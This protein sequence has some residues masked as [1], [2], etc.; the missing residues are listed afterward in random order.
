MNKK[1]KPSLT[2]SQ[3]FLTSTKT[4]TRLLDMTTIDKNDHILEIGAGKGHITR[5]LLKKSGKVTAVEMDHLLYCKLAND[6]STAPGL[7]LLNMDFLSM[8]LPDREPYKVFSNIPF[9]ITTDIM[10]KLS[11][12]PNPPM[13]SWLVMEKGA[14]KRFCGIPKESLLSLSWKPYFEFRILYHFRR[15]DFHPMPS[16]DV[17]LLY[18]RRKAPP[19]L[20]LSDRK[21]LSDFLKYGIANGPTGL[22]TKK[23]IAAAF[24]QRNLPPLNESDFLSYEQWIGLFQTWKTFYDTAKQ[25]YMTH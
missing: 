12:A 11:D 10:R 16:A 5:Q 15:Q 21:K 22:L 25:R 19:E 14:A 6:L 24:R 9:S 23:Q 18:I 7:H 3:N 13:E 2:V 20:P 1:I 4:I 8:R 17:A